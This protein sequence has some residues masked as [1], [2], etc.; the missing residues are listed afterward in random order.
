MNIVIF[1]LFFNVIYIAGSN[2]MSQ[3]YN[4]NRLALRY[5]IF[6]K[7]KLAKLLKN[8]INKFE[9]YHNKSIISVAQGIITYNEL[10]EDKKTIIETVISLC[11]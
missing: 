10:P 1:F 8:I 11:Y 9:I 4:L 5:V 6:K 7:K 2:S 3:K